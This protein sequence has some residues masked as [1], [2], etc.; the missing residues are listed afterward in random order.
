DPSFNT[1]SSGELQNWMGAF[2]AGMADILWQTLGLISLILPAA[3]MQ[4]GWRIGRQAILP[5]WQ[6][7]L[8]ALIFALTIGALG[9][10]C[11]NLMIWGKAPL[12]IPAGGTFGVI[13]LNLFP[14]LSLGWTIALAGSAHI[15]T[16]ALG[17]AIFSIAPWQAWGSITAA[18]DWLGSLSDRRT[19]NDADEDEEEEEYE[20]EDEEEESRAPRRKLARVNA[21]AAKAAKKQRARKSRQLPSFGE[22]SFELPPMELLT[23]AP[24]GTQ[25]KISKD[26]LSRNAELLMGVLEE[27]GINGEITDVH[28]GPVVT[29][30]ELQPAAG[31][32]SSRVVSLADDIARSMSATAA[33]V[34]VIPGRNAIGIELPNASRETVFLR[35]LFETDVYQDHGARLPLVLGKDI[36]G[37]P[38]IADLAKM[39]HLLVAGTTGSGKSV[40]V[41][42]MILS[43]LYRLPPQECRLIMIDPKML[44]LSIYDE[45]PHLLT[46]VVTEP[47]KAIVA[48]KWTVREME[49]RYRAM[50]KLGVRNIDGYNQRLSEARASGETLSRKVQTGFDP[51]TGKPIHEDEPLD[52][53]NLPHIVV[54]VDE[55]ADLMLV[56]GKEIEGAIQRLA[57]MARAAGIH[58]IMATQRPS[59]DVIT[60][61]IKA[62]FPTRISF[63]VTSKI[64]SRTILGE[65]GAEQL[66]GMGDMLYM[67]AGGR[68]TRVHGPF[69]KD[70]EVEKITEFLR[71]QGAPEYIEDVTADP[72]EE[73]EE[74]EEAEAMDPMFD[75]AVAV[76][77]REGKASTS[78]IQRHLQIGY[79][80]A[81]RIIEAM[82]RQGMVSAANATGKRE[83][84]LRT[85]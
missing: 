72:E 63:Q 10:A 35:E 5:W 20:E 30:Y 37:A 41:N 51:D 11:W 59:V 22:D 21:P 64:D 6:L 4:W 9:F 62:N 43:L 16:L 61:T 24:E 13:L 71:A 57:Q 81:A 66:L 26:A 33:R 80:R 68:I 8:P 17:M 15:L 76:V 74:G 14:P 82:E 44:E 2:G 48:L 45:I 12:G 46:P 60:G 78:F 40:A 79:N 50:S 19:S 32:K 67:A 38:I 85:G 29:L 55:F 3:L 23:E 56:A 34:A 69:V 47:K 7:K 39:P 1:A 53:T 36:S 54:V 77:A 42:A 58:L 27:F 70:S 31:V 18:F 28:P 25:K 83:I 75:K 73:G 84:Y 52:L 49:D 65:G